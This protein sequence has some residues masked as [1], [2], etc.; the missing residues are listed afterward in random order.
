MPDVASTSE[1]A[2]HAVPAIARE[3]R[4]FHLF[5]RLPVALRCRGLGGPPVA[6][7]L[8]FIT[9]TPIGFRLL[10]VPLEVGRGGLREGLVLEL[11]DR[12]PAAQAGGR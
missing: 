1:S 6:G 11:L 9:L 2:P 4:F 10:G 7:L 12:L 3:I 8:G 5:D